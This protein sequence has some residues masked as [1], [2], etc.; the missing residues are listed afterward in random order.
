MIVSLLLACSGEAPVEPAVEG[1]RSGLPD[2]LVAATWQVRLADDAAR[3]PFEGREGWVAWSE[4]RPAD[5]LLA[6]AAEGDAAAL[7]RAHAELAVDWRLA[8]QLASRATVEVYGRT[9]MA[10]DPAEVAGLVAAARAELGEAPEGTPLPR[11]EGWAS[12]AAPGTLPDA[13]PVPHYRFRES[14]PE[15]LEV[16]AV[17]PGAGFALAAA[18]RAAAV[19]AD[20][21]SAGLVAWMDAAWGG[22][23]PPPESP[24]PTTV[25]DAWLF[26]SLATTPAD[27]VGFGALPP[28]TA[29]AAA[30]TGSPFAVLAAACLPAEDPVGC[31]ESAAAGLRA[32]LTAKMAE[33][34]GEP[35]PYH[36]RFAAR[37]EVGALVHLARVY[38]RRAGPCALP[39]GACEGVGARDA[40]AAGR[41]RVSA[42]DRADGAGVSE[43]LVWLWIAA[44]DVGNRNTVRAAELLHRAS[45]SIP[46]LDAARVPLDALHLRVSRSAAPGLPVH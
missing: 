31:A 39:G 7:A 45:A 30:S 12:Q 1:P 26:L 9:P 19:A 35:R 13:G 36:R 11:P 6:F 14:L 23:A 21:G 43:S 34:A 27:L 10:G 29:E 42:L 20:P 8:G 22:E 41:L 2:T 28:D 32:E 46:G 44:W 3:A 5:A 15:G 18:H 16:P 40:D 4:G 24:R 25:P 37:A 33:V 17:H 38:E